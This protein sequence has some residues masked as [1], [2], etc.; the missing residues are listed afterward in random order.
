MS[1]LKV[2][3][4]IAIPRRKGNSKKD[5]DFVCYDADS[6]I[7]WERRL[8]SLTDSKGRYWYCHEFG[9]PLSEAQNFV[10]EIRKDYPKVIHRENPII[11]NVVIARANDLEELKDLLSEAI[12]Q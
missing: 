3:L 2:N 11:I 4:H 5:G 7:P 8:F 6:P 10:N 1:F 9:Q 12:V